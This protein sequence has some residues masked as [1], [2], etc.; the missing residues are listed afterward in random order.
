MKRILAVSILVIITIPFIFNI[1]GYKNGELSGYEY[2]KERPS[3]NLSSIVSLKYQKRVERYLKQRVGFSDFLI[4]FSN[5]LRYRLFRT[6]DVQYVEVG[7]ENYLYMDSYIR[8]YLGIDYQG[9]PQIDSTVAKLAEIR[10]SL[11]TKGVDIFFMIAPGK[12]TYYPEYLPRRYL[13]QEPSTSNYE[14]YS[15]AF[16]R[17]N[18][19]YLDFNSWINSLK[20]TVEYELFSNTSVHWGQYACYLAMDSLTNYFNSIYGIRLPTLRIKNIELSKTMYGSDDDIEKLMNLLSDIPNKPMPRLEI[21]YDTLD[22]DNLR[23]LCMGDSYYFG[24]GDLGFIHHVFKGSKFW[25][26]FKEVIGKEGISTYLWEYDDLKKEIEK[27]D[28]I[29]IIFTEGNLHTSPKEFVDNLYYLYCMEPNYDKEL[30]WEKKRFKSKIEKN[31]EWRDVIVEKAKRN[32]KTIEEAIE[33]DAEY[34]AKE[35]LKDKF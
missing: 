1:F 26:Y 10:D 33:D 35:Y 27:N 23:V 18:I 4:R 30:E 14:T 34:M 31:S 32:K 11:K 12:G 28:L 20:D 21:E 2:M 3:L 5:E 22:R 25:Y 7:K 19:N 16:Y 29:F 15:K 24:L 9:E 17:H 8:S 13:S 6:S